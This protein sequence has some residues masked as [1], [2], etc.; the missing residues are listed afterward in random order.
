MFQW[1]VLVVDSV[2]LL[3]E[4]LQKMALVEV[5]KMVLVEVLQ[6]M[7]LLFQKMV[8]LLQLGY[9][10]TFRDLDT[11]VRATMPRCWDRRASDAGLRRG[12][13]NRNIWI[14][15]KHGI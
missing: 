10:K 4:V 11:V 6:K 15:G 14:E 2:L 1:L 3:V 12:L 13:T 9:L 7:V 5:Q 8:L